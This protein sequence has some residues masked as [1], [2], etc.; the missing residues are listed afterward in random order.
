MPMLIPIDFETRS[1]LN[2]KAVGAHIY[3]THPSTEILSIACRLPGEEPT[4]IAHPEWGGG[5]NEWEELRSRLSEHMH[6]GAI[7]AAHNSGFDRLIYWHV[8]DP[9]GEWSDHAPTW[10]KSWI[11]TAVLARR[12][13]YPSGL[14]DIAKA[15]GIEGKDERGKYFI[16]MLGNAN[17]PRPANWKELMEG[18]CE[19]GLQ[20]VVVLEGIMRQMVPYT[21]KQWEAFWANELIN[22]IGLPVD[23]DL[24]H[25]AQELSEAAKQESN[26]E[27][28]KITGL[29]PNG[30]RSK[31]GMTLGNHVLKAEWMVE[32]LEPY[33][34]LLACLQRPTRNEDGTPKYGLDEFARAQLREKLTDGEWADRVPTA[35]YDPIMAFLDALED[36]QGAA[37]SKFKALQQRAGNDHRLRGAYWHDGAGAT[38][39]GSSKGAQ[40]Q[41]LVNQTVPDLGK[42]VDTLLADHGSLEAKADALRRDTGLGLATALGRLVRP[43][44][45]APEGRWLV[46]ADYA[47]V[48]ARGLPWLADNEGGQRRL[49]LFEAGHDFYCDIASAIYQRTIT[50]ANDPEERSVGKGVELGSGYGGGVGAFRK[51]TRKFKLKGIRD[52]QIKEWVDIWRQENPWATDFWWDVNAAVKKAYGTP[53]HTFRAGKLS[54]RFVPQLLGGT[55]LCQLP[56]GRHLIYAHFKQEWED[57]E[58]YGRR[59]VF[60]CRRFRRGQMRKVNLWHGTFV[61][62]ATQAACNDILREALVRTLEEGLMVIGHTHDEIIVECAED[63]VKKTR[64][65]LSEAMLQRS[66][67]LGGFPL[68]VSIEDGERYEKRD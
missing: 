6:E 48:E 31:A 10:V 28:Q 25:A 60:T 59:R 40:L 57:H 18:M 53:G 55:L 49:D 22:D 14:G 39:R 50:K 36:G 26:A 11:C 62:N 64:E 68:A 27:L 13:C 8:Y 33:P 58:E 23:L 63:E 66:T 5:Y 67:W 38:G 51:T 15:L 2:V 29:Y 7:F 45:K 16:K 34:E 21:P 41:N 19:Y 56:S 44:I 54:Y 37:A 3:A 12:A 32:Q 20:D 47:G 35:V 46:W 42:T 17:S 4:S 30:E 43:A 61:E 65:Y 24:C 9:E 1:E 52:A